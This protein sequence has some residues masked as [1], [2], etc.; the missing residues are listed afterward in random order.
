MENPAG[1]VRT[2]PTTGSPEITGRSAVCAEDAVPSTPAV[3]A[4]AEHAMA[5]SPVRL[6]PNMFLSP[7]LAPR[8]FQN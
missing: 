3:M 2:P 1:A 7:F 5:M 4:I 8:E 6:L